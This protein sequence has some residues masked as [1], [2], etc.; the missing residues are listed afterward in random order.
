MTDVNSRNQNQSFNGEFV[1][2][3]KD[4]SQL[5][6]SSVES[7]DFAAAASVIK[8]LSDLRE[9]NLYHELG[10][11]TRALHEAIKNLSIDYSGD[12]SKVETFDDASN[13]L[14]YVIKLTNN[15]ANKTLDLVEESLPVSEKLSDTSLKLSE[16]WQKM[17]N[18]ELSPQ[19]FRELSKQMD[20]FLQS[21][22]K[23]SQSLQQNLS[24]ILLAQDYQDLTGQ[25]I[26]KVAE[27]LKTAE[28]SL[29]ELV[30]MASHFESIAGVHTQVDSSDVGQ[31]DHDIHSG[32]GPCINPEAQDG[33]VANQ[34]EVDDLLS[35]LGF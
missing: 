27:I 28:S 25:V 2:T 22:S 30:S 35:S 9:R 3:V 15:A 1:N 12:S 23:D 29:V 26:M 19:E 8:N 17:L 32:C 14:D 20:K 4:C 7:G 21:C 6:S 24:Q 13:R 10:H 33:V 34:D 31:A 11:L 16:D 5:L 18:R